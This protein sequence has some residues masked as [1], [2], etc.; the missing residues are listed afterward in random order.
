MM[1]VEIIQINIVSQ[2]GAKCLQKPH[3]FTEAYAYQTS[4]DSERYVLFKGSQLAYTISD[5]VPVVVQY[6]VKI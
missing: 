6:E 3:D 4:E 2:Q 5:N 1:K